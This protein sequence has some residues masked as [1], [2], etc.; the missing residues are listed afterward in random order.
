MDKKIRV[1]VIGSGN[2]AWHLAPE[3]DN[4]GYFVTEVYSRDPT[5]A[6]KLINRLYNASLKTNLDFS[7]SDSIV[8][9]IAIAD[10]NIIE[11]AKEIA[12]PDEAIL[13]HTSGG[14]PLEVLD[15]ASTENI[16]VFYPLQ[17]F[18]KNKKVKFTNIPICVET[19]NDYTKNLLTTIGKKIS[20]HVIFVKEEERKI[21]HIAAVFACNFTN[22][23][24]TLSQDLT[25]SKDLDF[26]ILKPLI[27]ETIE[28]A[29]DIGPDEA[30][31]GPAIRKDFQIIQ[32]HL[33]DLE[34][35]NDLKS[36]YNLITQHII[37]RYNY[38][39]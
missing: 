2:V 5:N 38:S 35:N 33:A 9:I 1:S 21:L 28:K 11:I 10:D 20:N 12:L 19:R 26:G 36:I 22:H 14:Q 8:F 16:G 18:S 29:L 37:N 27:I 39:N 23:M 17:T 32:N 15:F 25:K 7:N 31:T 30:Q 13:V 3:L 4:H 34:N 24:L 6:Q